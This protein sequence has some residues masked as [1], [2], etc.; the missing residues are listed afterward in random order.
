MVFLLDHDA[1]REITLQTFTSNVSQNGHKISFAHH[2]FSLADINRSII[3]VRSSKCIWSKF[4]YV[5]LD[6]SAGRS[7]AIVLSYF[8][9][10]K[11]VLKY[12]GLILSIVLKIAP[13]QLLLKTGS[14]DNA[15][16]DFMGLAI[17]I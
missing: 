5:D 6:T 9:L 8:A 1:S 11:V 14:L 12:Q 3:E 17:M 2:S 7:S 16:Q 4:G 15:I 13:Y 10:K